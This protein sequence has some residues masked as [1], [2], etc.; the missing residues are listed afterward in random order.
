MKFLRHVLLM[1]L[2]IL[3]MLYSIGQKKYLTESKK[4]VVSIPLDD[5]KELTL[6]ADVGENVQ[7]QN[8]WLK[9]EITKQKEDIL[10]RD[11][12]ISEQKVIINSL[13]IKAKRLLVLAIVLVFIIVLIFYIDKKMNR[14]R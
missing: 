6:A 5:L 2:L 12:L 14:R 3:P 11:K 13:D 4:E 7:R 1:I 9:A 8:I 10:K